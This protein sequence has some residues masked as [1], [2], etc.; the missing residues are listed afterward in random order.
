MFMKSLIRSMIPWLLLAG[1]G[2]TPHR[3]SNSVVGHERIAD[4]YDATANSIEEE[5]FKARRDELTVDAPSPCWKAQD[6]RFLEANRNAAVAH[7]AAAAQMRA[8]E[9]NV[10]RTATASR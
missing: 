5:C 6:I 2:S 1:C 3:N 8:Q 10:S 4:H 9:T 7:R